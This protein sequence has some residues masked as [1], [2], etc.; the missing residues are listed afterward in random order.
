L[1]GLISEPAALRTCLLAQDG[2]SEANAWV[3]L[4]QLADASGDSGAAVECFEGAA[5]IA[6]EAREMGLLKRVNCHIGVAKGH[7]SQAA[8]FAKLAAFARAGYGGGA[9]EDS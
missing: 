6:S 4:G 9:A 7:A 8:H 3:L 5:S 2:A 1:C